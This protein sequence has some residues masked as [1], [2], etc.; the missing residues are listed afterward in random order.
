MTTTITESKIKERTLALAEKIADSIKI[1]KTTGVGL[2]EGK[3]YEDNLPEGITID[4]VK[5]I[6][7]YDADFVAAGTLAFGKLS[8]D[9]M[10]TS[11]KLEH[12]NIEIAMGN[13]VTSVGFDRT[14]VYT[15]SLGKE[16]EPDKITKY[17]VATTTFEVR[18]GKNSGDLKHARRELNALAQAAFGK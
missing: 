1:D 16:G 17:G 3:V 4:T 2:S 10:K 9:A 13:N 12:T 5:N 11:K 7:S 15:N 8:I 6:N 18:A 14:R